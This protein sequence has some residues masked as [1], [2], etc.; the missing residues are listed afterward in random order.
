MYGEDKYLDLLSG[1]RVK[2]FIVNWIE[3][4]IFKTYVNKLLISWF[5]FIIFESRKNSLSYFYTSIDF[6]LLLLFMF[7]V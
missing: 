3:V 7:N 5:Y 2:K 1:L 4:H 6:I